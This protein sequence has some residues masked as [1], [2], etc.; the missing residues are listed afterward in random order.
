M[1]TT[2]LTLATFVG[3]LSL[4]GCSYWNEEAGAFLDQGEFGNATLNNQL[5]HTCRRIT[6]ANISKY[7]NPISAGCPGRIQDGKYAMFAYE[8]TIQSAT[9]TSSS[10][11]EGTNLE[12][13]Q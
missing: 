7:G 8:E 10:A 3:A 9:E 4:G 5:A 12:S 13:E 11:V 6:S 2:T 1:K